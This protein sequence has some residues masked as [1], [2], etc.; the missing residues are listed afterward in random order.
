MCLKSTKKN[1]C[2][3]ILAYVSAEEGG[4]PEALEFCLS[5]AHF[6][7]KIPYHQC[8]ILI[9]KDGDQEELKSSS[10]K[11]E[12]RKFTSLGEEQWQA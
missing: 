6:L 4:N 3:G 2:G 8:G 11:I 5:K 7:Q 1:E 9:R 12:M 10:E